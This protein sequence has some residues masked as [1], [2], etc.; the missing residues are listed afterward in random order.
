MKKLSISLIALVLCLLMLA[1]CM[2]PSKTMIEIEENGTKFTISIEQSKLFA[3]MDKAFQEG[4]KVKD[5]DSIYDDLMVMV[6]IVN[7]N[8]HYVE[9][10]EYPYIMIERNP[11]RL[12]RRGIIVLNNQEEDSFKR[13]NEAFDATPYDL[14]II[15]V[16]PGRISF[17][18]NNRLYA[19]VYIEDNSKPT[20]M[21]WPDENRKIKVEKIR[22]HWYHVFAVG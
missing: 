16:H 21:T 1:G 3:A 15:A 4:N 10:L 22:S 2:D 20:Y 18:T 17:D 6:D 8:R 12:E 11:L 7:K 5:F 9:K 13:V 14:E 19:L